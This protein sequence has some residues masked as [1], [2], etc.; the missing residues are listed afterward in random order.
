AEAERPLAVEAQAAIKRLREGMTRRIMAVAPGQGGALVAAS[1]TGDRAAISPETDKAL[2]DA[3]LAHLIAISGLNMALATGVVF[4][5]TRAALAA[6]PAVA[7]R[8]P[9]KKWAA[10]AALAA[11]LFYIVISGGAWSAWRAFIMA[12]VVLVAILVDRRALSMRN[13]A[14]AATIILVLTPE[15]VA[16]PGFQMSFA[17][18]A[19]LIA[20]YV[21]WRARRGAEDHDRGILARA[22]RYAVG[23]VATD[24]VASSATGFFSLHHFHRAALFGLPANILAGPLIAFVLMPFAVIGVALMPFGLD[25]LAMK[26]AALGGDGVVAVG[27]L[28]AGLPGGVLTTPPA[29]P[30]AL[31]LATAGGL[32]LCLNHAPWRLLG[33]APLA[34]AILLFATARPPDL[35]VSPKGDLAALS[36]PGE[37]RLAVAGAGARNAFTLGVWMEAV[38]LDKDRDRT[39]PLRLK[40]DCRDGV[41]LVTRRGAGIAVTQDAAAAARACAG[42]FDLVVALNAAPSQCAARMIGPGEAKS[43][44]AHAVVIRRDGTLVV[45]TVSAARG[46][47][48]WSA[49]FAP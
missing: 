34:L 28:I 35:L 6:I 4:F 44:G 15:A 22:R 29:P 27:R 31:A 17:A 36:L 25:P 11:G 30:L 33:A 49:P 24:V 42:A 19:A 3:G 40:A 20:A 14:I 41:C 47:R 37:R 48:P 32:W 46:K 16:Q 13:V 1:I 18:V 10:L 5:A 2:R 23:L 9:I 26:I 39:T 8:W 12:A 43:D 21:W 38:G 7:L 45:R